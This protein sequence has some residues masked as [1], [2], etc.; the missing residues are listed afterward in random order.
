MAE[1]LIDLETANLDEHVASGVALVDF[2]ATWC[3][4]CKS[5]TPILEKVKASIGEKASI[6]KVD[7]DKLPEL[8]AQHGVRSIPTLILFKEGEIVK[9]MVG[10]QK[11]PDLEELILSN[12]D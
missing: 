2:W 8:A 11:Q 7:V 12:V 3:G 9:T 10:L 5:Q 4:P 6:I 1:G